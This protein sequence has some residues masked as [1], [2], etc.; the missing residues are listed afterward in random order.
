MPIQKGKKRRKPRSRGNGESTV[1]SE[2]PDTAKAKPVKQTRP[3]FEAP[4]WLNLALGTG[5]VLFG[6]VFFVISIVG[7]SAISTQNV[8]ILVLY[9]VVAGLYLG[10]AWRQRTAA[11]R[12]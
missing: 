1:Y 2:A 7:G 10:K 11:G 12:Q 9:L 3:R 6:V 8:I 5:M 4:L